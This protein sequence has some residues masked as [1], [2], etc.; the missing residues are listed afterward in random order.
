MVAENRFPVVAVPAG[1]HYRPHRFQR[2]D[3][4]GH[5]RCGA[6]SVAGDR[7]HTRERSSGLVDST[8][9]RC[10][11]SEAGVGDVGVED[12]PVGDLGEGEVSGYGV[13]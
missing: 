5:R 13:G 8:A 9:D 7:C 3:G 12:D 4:R 10:V 11:H 1:H 6:L 2:V